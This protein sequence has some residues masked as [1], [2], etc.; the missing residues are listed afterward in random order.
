MCCRVTSVPRQRV[1]PNTRVGHGQCATDKAR[2]AVTQ[3][4]RTETT[5][6]V[7]CCGL[8]ATQNRPWHSDRK[9]IDDVENTV[10]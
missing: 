9:K 10:N 3:N 4:Y 1:H 5:Y 7:F 6:T 8:V 2:T